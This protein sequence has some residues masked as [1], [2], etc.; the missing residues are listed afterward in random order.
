MKH[1]SK[2][3]KTEDSDYVPSED[4]YND[5]SEEEK[6]K[7]TLGFRLAYLDDSLWSL[8]LPYGGVGQN[9]A[10]LLHRGPEKRPGGPR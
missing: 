5:Y 7:Y 9:I 4:E 8:T 6:Y 2:R 3:S 10:L 1:S